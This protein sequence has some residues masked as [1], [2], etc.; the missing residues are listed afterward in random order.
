[1]Y[2]LR[3]SERALYG[4]NY[5]VI[6]P[7]GKGLIHYQED[8][9]YENRL[10]GYLGFYSKF[11]E[12]TLIFYNITNCVR[13]SDFI[14][15]RKLSR[16]QY[17]VIIDA[18]VDAMILRDQYFLSEN[19]LLIHQ[20]YI[21]IKD[22]SE[23]AFVYLPVEVSEDSKSAL[24]DFVAWLTSM[25]DVSEPGAGEAS[26]PLQLVLNSPSF[27]LRVVK[28]TITQILSGAP[29][30][31]IQPQRVPP[32]VSRG[33]EQTRARVPD[34]SVESVPPPPQRNKSRDIKGGKKQEANLFGIGVNK[35]KPAGEKPSKPRVKNIKKRAPRDGYGT[36]GIPK[37]SEGYYTDTPPEYA[38]P[39]KLIYD[40]STDN[41]AG[42]SDGG[43]GKGIFE[44]TRRI[45]Y[46]LYRP[47]TPDERIIHV[48][49]SPF[50]I[51]RGENADYFINDISISREHAR[52]IIEGNKVFLIDT[53]SKFGTY[54]NDRRLEPNMPLEINDDD[55]VM[56]SG[57]MY[58]VKIMRTDNIYTTPR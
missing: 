58:S 16:R 5:L 57:L 17:L 15:A 3:T 45:V 4:E 2:S 10:P 1:M 19:S 6:A 13:L 46:L 52:I 37:E 23:I 42:V 50:T 26:I 41:P 44:D 32:P 54:V 53:Q 49:K 38:I 31:A 48:D 24:R 11:E 39:E 18:A 51:G 43:Y 35:K 20:D 40:K 56:F 25:L 8:M 27:V 55:S 22:N 14:G 36:H 47:N 7:E 21:F 30:G 12:E 33:W 29:A 28:E 34:E 9:I